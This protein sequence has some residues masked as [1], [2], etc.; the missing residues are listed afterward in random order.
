MFRFCNVQILSRN[1]FNTALFI[2]TAVAFIFP[3]ETLSA[4]QPIDRI[5]A[6]VE[7]DIILAS[8]LDKRLN[9]I[10]IQNRGKPLPS[11]RELKEQVLENMII[12][13]IQLQMA[14]RGGMRVDEE[15]LNETIR[16]IAQQNGMSM[17]QFRSTMESEGISFAEAREQI[18]NELLTSRVQRF[19]VGERIQITDQDIDYFLESDLGK[20]SSA[21]EYKLRHIL[22]SVPSSAN[23]EEYQAVE[24]KANTL[25]N[26]LR[27]GDDFAAVAMAESNSGSALKG[28]DLGWRKEGQLPGLFAD[29]VPTLEVG[30]IADLIT[31]PSGFHIVKLEDKRGGSSQLI[32]QTKVRHILLQTNEIRD[33]TRAEREINLIYEQLISGADFVEL[34][35]Q[36]SDDPGS[37][38]NGGDLGWVNPGDMVPSFDQTMAAT[39]A[40]ELSKPFKSQFGWHV[41]LVED[42]RETDVGEE[43]QRNKVRQMLYS[44]RFEEELPIWLRKT[45]SEAYVELRN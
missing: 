4:P 6:V 37:G 24:S 26:R 28:G 40:G 14:A 34:A 42:R 33:E 35:K 7:D 36:H 43:V 30:A 39:S 17:E 12:E 41:L 9:T 22:L 18:R 38:S 2:F 8:E 20:M 1:L 23:P 10:K 11:D 16:G 15:E 5:I 27:N 13:S 25:L 29:I 19:S 3:Q 32:M 44:R 45:R 31:T 21:A